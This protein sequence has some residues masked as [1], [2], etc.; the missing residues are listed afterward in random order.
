MLLKGSLQMKSV[1]HRVH[2]VCD[3]HHGWNIGES[4]NLS[5]KEE[6]PKTQT[7]LEDTAN[8]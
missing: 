4:R 1:L 8:E 2:K 7:K 6:C 5:V 3:T